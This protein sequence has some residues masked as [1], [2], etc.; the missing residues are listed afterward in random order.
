MTTVDTTI[1]TPNVTPT[2][3]SKPA[4][5]VPPSF[6]GEI[7]IQ[8]DTRQQKKAQHVAYKPDASLIIFFCA[9]HARRNEEGLKAKGIL[10]HPP[11]EQYYL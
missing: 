8:C 3:E 5:I 10:I 1:V 11:V 9:H 7:C 6:V 4:I 2:D